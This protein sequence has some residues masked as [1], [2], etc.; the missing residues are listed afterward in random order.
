MSGA[1]QDVISGDVHVPEKLLRLMGREARRSA[2]ASCKEVAQLCYLTCRDADRSIRTSPVALLRLGLRLAGP[3]GCA[4]LRDRPTSIRTPIR[5][6][7]AFRLTTNILHKLV[8]AQF[9][10]SGLRNRNQSPTVD[11]R[12][13]P[14][15][16]S[17]GSWRL[18]AATRRTPS[19]DRPDVGAGEHL[20]IGP[21]L[22]MS[23][24]AASTNNP[25]S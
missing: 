2:L 1:E 11:P 21:M 4:L 13:R 7:C 17:W 24:Q 6:F 15:P 12:A 5:D 23:T 14:S 19:L 22:G 25:K 18:R 16:K 8:M 20:S 10:K 3:P 9:N